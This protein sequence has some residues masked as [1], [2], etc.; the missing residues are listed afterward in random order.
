MSSVYSTGRWLVPSPL[1]AI[2]GSLEERV[3]AF[4]MPV[5]TAVQTRGERVRAWARM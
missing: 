5:I 1:N 4:G 2:A 3:A